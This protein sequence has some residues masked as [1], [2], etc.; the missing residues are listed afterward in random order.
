MA[1]Q[2]KLIIK[3]RAGLDWTVTLTEQDENGNT[4]PLNLTGA[5][6]EFR[7][8]AREADAVALLSLSSAAGG[9]PPQCEIMTPATAGKVLFRFRPPYSAALK[10]AFAAIEV[11]WSGG[12]APVVSEGEIVIEDHA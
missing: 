12:A 2:F 7:A 6:V 1:A 4:V 11:T 9:S 5:T 8:K 10:L 3:R